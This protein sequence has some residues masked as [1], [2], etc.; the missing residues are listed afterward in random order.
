MKLRRKL[1]AIAFLMMICGVVAGTAEAHQPRFPGPGVTIVSDPDVSQAWYGRLNG[2][3]AE[4]WVDVHDS[5][6]LYV[7]VLAPR[8]PRV[9]KDYTVVVSTEWNGVGEEVFELDGPNSTWTDFFEPFAGD[10]YWQGPEKRLKVGPGTYK[11]VVS[12]P[13]NEGKY[14]LAIGER[15]SFPPGEIAR[16]VGQMPKLKRYFGKSVWTSYF[17]YTG[18]FV[19]VTAAVVAGVV[20]LIASLAHH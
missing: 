20:V 19:G 12:D 11:V 16:L 1:S 17:N 3:P 8:I 14:V 13:G 18:I 5:L 4:Y 10:H 9:T 2:E 7:S 6:L 15:E